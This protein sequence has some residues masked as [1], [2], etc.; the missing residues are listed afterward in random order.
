MTNP[1][2]LSTRV[3]EL[4]DE[5]EKIK[6]ASLPLANL[7]ALADRLHHVAEM[8]ETYTDVTLSSPDTGEARRAGRVN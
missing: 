5:L 2:Y 1:T 6:P 7:T 4:L 8:I 3:Y